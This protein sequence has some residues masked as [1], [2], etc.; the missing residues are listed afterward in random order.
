MTRP[1]ALAALLA[2][3]GP[4]AGLRTGVA[5]ADEATSDEDE[6]IVPDPRAR[7]M[8]SEAN[9]EPVRR[10]EGLAF[11]FGIGGSM[12]V[13]FGEDLA[14]ASRSGGAANLRFGT[15]ASDKLTWFADIF[16]AAAPP[17]GEEAEVQAHTLLCFGAQYFLLE[18]LWLRAS[19]GW[20]TLPVDELRRDGLGSLVGGGI[21]FLRRGRFAL[22]G[23][24]TFASSIYFKA[25][26]LTAV[27]TQLGLTW[28]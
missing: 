21:D 25:G 11:G 23:N 4:S 15:S 10:R 24:L 27:S 6:P 2:L 16:F 1:V 5:H 8:A 7:R 17:D 3:A 13:G 20:A 14:G 12:Q 9:L 28:Y 18:A 26:F 19:L 22:S